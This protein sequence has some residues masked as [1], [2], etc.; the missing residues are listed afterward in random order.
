MT[1]LHPFNPKAT[2]GESHARSVGPIHSARSVVRGLVEDD[3]ETDDLA[4]THAEVVR[5][6]N[7]VG[8]IGPVERTVVGSAHNR[9]AVVVEDLTYIDGYL[10]S[11]YILCD[12]SADG[13]NSNELSVVVVDIGVCGECGN[14]ATGIAGVD[15]IDVLDRKSTRLNSSHI[16]RSRMPSSA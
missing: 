1:S 4:V 3:G 5:Q 6:N 8:Q 10:I 9:L 11:D 2:R 14:G 15:R 13:V 12:P 16:T 7:L